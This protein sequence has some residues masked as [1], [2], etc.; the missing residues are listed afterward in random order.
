MRAVRLLRPTTTLKPAGVEYTVTQSPKSNGSRSGSSPPIWTA[1]PTYPELPK[2]L[3]V[4]LPLKHRD[5]ATAQSNTTPPACE[6]VHRGRTD[7][8]ADGHHQ[9]ASG[10]LPRF[11]RQQRPVRSRRERGASGRP[12]TPSWTNGAHEPE[13]VSAFGGRRRYFP[14]GRAARPQAE[15]SSLFRAGR[16]SMTVRRAV[17]RWELRRTGWAGRCSRYP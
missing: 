9:T 5:G 3:T 7:R 6:S 14:T 2:V 10:G 4:P 11:P 13:A 8:Q 16:M 17:F 15:E 12:C 1:G